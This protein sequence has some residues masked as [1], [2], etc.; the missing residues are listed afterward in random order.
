M[1]QALTA[2]WL[3][4]LT[5][6]QIWDLKPTPI[7]PCLGAVLFLL[8]VDGGLL[9][10]TPKFGDFP[11]HFYVEEAPTEAFNILFGPALGLAQKIWKALLERGISPAPISQLPDGQQI[12]DG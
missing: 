1:V 10:P 8:C 3:L 12:M 7:P 2:A 4:R 6:V 11:M 5:E 9:T